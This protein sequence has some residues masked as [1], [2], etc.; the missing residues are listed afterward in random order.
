MNLLLKEQLYNEKDTIIKYIVSSSKK[1][2]QSTIAY[3]GKEYDPQF[4]VYRGEK[5][6]FENELDG[7]ISLWV[8][9]LY[10]VEEWKYEYDMEFATNIYDYWIMKEMTKYKYLKVSPKST[11]NYISSRAKEMKVKQLNRRKEHPIDYG[12]VEYPSIAGI[13]VDKI[14]CKVEDFHFHISGSIINAIELSSSEYGAGYKEFFIETE[15]EYIL[16]SE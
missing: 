15:T 14:I 11:F 13:Y 16:F 12:D 1:N 5:D 2:I 6:N 9:L 3:T 8:K 7:L 4:W 10:D